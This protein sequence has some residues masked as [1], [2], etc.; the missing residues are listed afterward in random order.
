MIKLELELEAVNDIL[1]VLG[2]LPTASGAW[3]LMQRIRAQAEAQA[4]S[5]AQA[6]ITQ[7]TDAA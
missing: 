6:E 7:E 1:N 3:P 5:Q 4:G 2:Q